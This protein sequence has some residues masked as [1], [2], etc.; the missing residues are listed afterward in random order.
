MPSIDA[1]ERFDY[2]LFGKSY[3]EVHEAIDAPWADMGLWHRCVFHSP[4]DV[5][6]SDPEIQHVVAAHQIADLLLSIFAPIFEPEAVRRQ[7]EMAAQVED[8]WKGWLKWKGKVGVH[9]R[10]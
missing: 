3:R 9:L 5:F 2:W 8:P 4:F 1:H 7:F 10:K 6:A